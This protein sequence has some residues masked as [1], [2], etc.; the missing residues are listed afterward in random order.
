MVIANAA[1]LTD[2][3]SLDTYRDWFKESVARRAAVDARA[4]GVPARSRAGR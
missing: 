3:A 1:D 4:R 2:L